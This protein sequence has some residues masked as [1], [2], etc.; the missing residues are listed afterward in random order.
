MTEW[1]DVP[2]FEGLYKISSDG[3][4]KSL[5]RVVTK[6]NGRT[7][8]INGRIKHPAIEHGYF[9]F[10]LYKSNLDYVKYL[11]RLVAESFIG[12]CPPD[13]HVHHING[14][15]QDNSL[16]NLAYIAPP[17]HSSIHSAGELNTFCKLD[18]KSVARIREQYAAGRTWTDL[19][20]EYN[21]SYHTIRLITRR[22]TWRHTK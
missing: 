22:E 14:N 10:T 19:A 7:Q 15:K 16:S 3:Q 20:S 11:H 18:A 21:V 6:S 9:R 8:T 1:R 13:Y 5:D 12:P 4:V 17:D 2:G